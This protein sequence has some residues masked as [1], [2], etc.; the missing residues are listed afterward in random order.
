MPQIFALVI[1][2]DVYASS[3]YKNLNAAAGDADAFEKFLLEGLN[4]HPSCITSLRNEK[5]TR[6][7]I[8][9]GFKILRDDVRIIRDEAAIVIYFAG[10]GARTDKPQEWGDWETTSQQIEMM[11]PTDIDTMVP[12]FDKPGE[13]ELVLGIPD[14]TVSVLL[15]HLSDVKGD[16]IVSPKLFQVVLSLNLLD[17]L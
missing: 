2:I 7:A 9:A 13:E 15:N 6:A 8:I 11:C 4:V 10:H 1:G 17:R 12:V 16:N 3:K 14:R 5:A